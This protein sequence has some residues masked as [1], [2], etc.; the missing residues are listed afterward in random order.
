MIS[1]VYQFIA[2]AVG[3]LSAEY[4]LRLGGDGLHLPL[5]VR[6]MLGLITCGLVGILISVP[7][8]CGA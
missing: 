2:R 5:Q 8:I 4:V 1:V 3:H 7:S 6:V